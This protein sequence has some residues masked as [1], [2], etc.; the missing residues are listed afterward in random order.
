M[1][2]RSS[3]RFYV[4]DMFGLKIHS[5]SQAGARWS[6]AARGHRRG[7]RTGVAQG[8]RDHEADPPVAG[9]FTVGV[10]TMAQPGL[11]FV[12]DILIAAKLGT[13]PVAEAFVVAFALPNMFRRFFAEGAFNM[14]FVP[15]FSKKVEGGDDPQG[16]A[17]DAFAGLATFLIVFTLLAQRRC[18]GWCWRWPRALPGTNASIWRAFGRIAFPYILFISLAALLSGVLNATGRFAAAAAAPVLL[19][20]VLIRDGW[21]RRARRD[22]GAGAVMG[23]ARGRASRN[24]R[25]SGSR[26]SG[27]AFA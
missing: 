22:I 13:G 18:R 9:F 16:F 15:M 26:R 5:E 27:R 24:W 1:A 14:A 7:H 12:R 8:A 4:K 11:G 6:Q 21:A 19:N 2:R 20:V 17:S 10:W 3:T 23:G 25:W